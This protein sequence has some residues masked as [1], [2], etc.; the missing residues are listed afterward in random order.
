MLKASPARLHVLLAKEA[1]TAVVFRRGPSKMTAVVGWNRKT[2]EF[3]V[4]QWLKGRIYERRSDLSPDGKHL[5]YFAMNGN[6]KSDA[7]GS[8][9]AI[10]KAPYLRALTLFPKGDCW[11]GGGLFLSSN[12]FWLN[13]GYGHQY[14][15]DGA[16]LHRSM[17]FPWHEE[18]GGECPG[19]YYI[20]LQ[21]DGWTMNRDLSTGDFTV[22]EKNRGGWRLRKKAYAT[23]NHPV[24]KGCYYDVHELIDVDTGET[25]VYEDWEWADFDRDRLVWAADGKLHAGGFGPNGLVE[26]KMLYDFNPMTFEALRAPY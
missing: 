10:S 19:V 18:Y 25:T 17:K 12:E 16:K 14:G 22:F 15:P 24:D 5:I 4:G 8:W 20:R 3:K 9:T 2:D 13:N 23:L 6:W 21:R 11:H 26:V 7:N 1:S